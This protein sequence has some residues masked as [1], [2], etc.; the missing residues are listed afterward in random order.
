MLVMSSQMPGAAAAETAPSHY[1]GARFHKADTGEM[2]DG[3]TARFGIII[4]T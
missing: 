2:V 3:V 4:A 1:P